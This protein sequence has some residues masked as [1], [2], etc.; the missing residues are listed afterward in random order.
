MEELGLINDTDYAFRYAKDLYNIKGYQGSRIINDLC[1]K[2][3]DKELAKE[4]AS[5][6]NENDET[7]KIYSIIEK[8]AKTSLSDAKERNRITGY[9]VR[10]GYTFSDINKS[11]SQYIENEE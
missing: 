1:R 8:R 6:F 4:A 2:G 7:E 10:R 5:Q 11:I 3:I 9:L